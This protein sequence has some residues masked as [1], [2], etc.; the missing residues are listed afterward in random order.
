MLT[1]NWQH[2]ILAASG[3]TGTSRRIARMRAAGASFALPYRDGSWSGDTW[4]PNRGES[5]QAPATYTPPF[6]PPDRFGDRTYVFEF[7][8]VSG[9]SSPRTSYR[10]VHD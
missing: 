1:V 7:W 10:A 8:S 9:S 6:S 4:S 3:Y 5:G 2:I